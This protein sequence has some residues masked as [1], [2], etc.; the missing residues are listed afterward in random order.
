[1]GGLARHRVPIR[2]RAQ[3]WALTPAH[4]RDRFY[5]LL[6]LD[7][8]GFATWLVAALLVVYLALN[9][10]GY[11]AIQRSEVGVAVWWV[12]LVGTAVGAL[13]V[14]WGTRYGRLA[15]GLLALFAGWTALSLIWT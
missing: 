8:A 2:R 3:V 11:D 15:F 6:R 10:G 1:M 5:V 7:P 9:N 4:P 13:S 12:V 14:A